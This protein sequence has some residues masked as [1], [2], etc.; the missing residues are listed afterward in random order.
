[1]QTH[2]LDK[3]STRNALRKQRR[4]LSQE[5][6]QE[7][8]S[9]LAAL[10]QTLPLFLNA[11]QVAFYLP[12][13]GE[14]NPLPL[15]ELALKQGK[16]CYLPKIHPANKPYLLF[17]PY[18]SE[19]SLLKNRY[20]ILESTISWTQAKM[21]HELDVVFTPLVAFDNK[22]NR[23]GMGKG[24]Y[25]YSFAFLRTHHYSK[26]QVQAFGLTRFKRHTQFQKLNA[27]PPKLIGLAHHFQQV[28]NIPTTQ[29]DVPLNMIVTDF[30]THIL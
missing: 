24:Y 12:H 10:A 7:A 17:A 1:M 4:S 27:P 20:G 30:A 13:D 5:Q 3:Q 9:N 28:E 2:L 14:I 18:F 26:Q 15:L 29:W 16:N 11:K 22:G 23:L 21:P 25:D 6:Q 8:A 19:Q